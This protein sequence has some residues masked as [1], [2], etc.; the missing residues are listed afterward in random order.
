MFLKPLKIF[1]SKKFVKYFENIFEWKFLYSS[2]LY[3]MIVGIYSLTD[4]KHYILVYH[5]NICRH[6]TQ[7]ITQYNTTKHKSTQQFF[8]YIYWF[9][10]YTDIRLLQLSTKCSTWST[11]EIPQM[12]TVQMFPN[13]MFFLNGLFIGRFLFHIPLVCAYVNMN[14]WWLRSNPYI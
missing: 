4:Y 6:N 8:Y 1:S 14:L 7:N 3:A 2:R 12:F 13:K 9:D 5:E 10:I 11:Q